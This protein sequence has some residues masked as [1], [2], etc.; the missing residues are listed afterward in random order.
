MKAFLLLFRAD[1]KEIAAAPPQEMEPR[2]KQWM[3]W[4][5]SI[6]AQNKLAAGGNHLSSTGKV[7]KKKKVTDGPYA[8]IKESILG[9]I[10]I[11]ESS[12]EEAVAWAQACPILE[13][14]GNSVEVR[15]IAT[16]KI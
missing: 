14:E 10:I 7:V 2:M 1:Y 6:A 13:G 15:E 8:E 4:I 12:Y 11:N 5:N 16:N 9:Y 3:D